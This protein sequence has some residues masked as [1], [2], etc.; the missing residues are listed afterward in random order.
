MYQR[1]QIKNFQ[2]L[3][4]VDLELGSLTIIRGESSSGKSALLRALRMLASNSR[5]HSFVT[6]GH[7]VSSVSLSSETWTVTLE[8]GEGVGEYK[9]YEET[10]A[11]QLYTKLASG[12]PELVS[13]RLGIPPNGIQFAAQHDAPFLLQE[14]GAGVAGV[15][16]EL[17]NVSTIFDA[18]RELN[19]RRLNLNSVLKT[20]TGDLESLERRLEQFSA[21]DERE[22]R[23][24]ALDTQMTECQQLRGSSS[25]LQ[26]FVVSLT[27]AAGDLSSVSEISVPS[28][29]DLENLVGEYHRLNHL[30]LSLESSSALETSSS[31]SIDELTQEDRRLHEKFH[32]TLLE[33]GKCPLCET[34]IQQI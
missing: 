29:E 2:S 12:V 17:T 1:V 16:G 34:V 27:K 10:K 28:T 30:L 6:L 26:A 23:L 33:A 3:Q 15:L 25:R 14:S 9:I 7:S 20:R 32:E 13:K 11:P 4:N 8:R 21:L 22:A 19:R 24:D 18:V 5:G 31:S